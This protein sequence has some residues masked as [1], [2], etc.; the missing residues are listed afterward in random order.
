MNQIEAQFN[1]AAAEVLGVRV[2]A[3]TVPQLHAAMGAIIDNGDHVLVLNA[4]VRAL[5]LAYEWPWF[6]H[7]LNQAGLIYCDGAGVALA[8]RLDGF[9]IPRRIT[10]ADWAWELAEFAQSCDYSFFLL[11]AQPGVA[12][13]AAERLQARFKRLRIVG[14]QHGYFNK[15]IDHPENQAVVES[16]NAVRP[17]I[18]ILGFGMPLQ[19]KWLMENWHRVDARIA[20]AG[21][22]VFDFISG[23]LQRAPAWMNDRG[24]EWLGRLLIEPGRLWQ[25]Y[26]VGNPLFFSRVLRHKIT[27]KPLPD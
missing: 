22:A 2:H 25:R 8:A 6:R 18:L 27:A 23:G 1:I 26:L 9:H 3:L 10:L 21:G 20:L 4:N 13:Q 24:F 14:V 12:E 16:I 15:A 5:N 7:F 11:G 19:E 17:D